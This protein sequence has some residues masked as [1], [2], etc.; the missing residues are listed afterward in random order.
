MTATNHH[1]VRSS[2][3][4]SAGDRIEAWHN[5]R[6]YHRGIVLK[7]VAGTELVWIEDVTTGRRRLLDLDSLEIC[8][9]PGPEQAGTQ[10]TVPAQHKAAAPAS[11]SPYPLFHDGTQAF[12]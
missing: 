8:R 12:T 11:V 6:L 9:V 1:P 5:G 2:V 7:S 3:E 4:L 10:T